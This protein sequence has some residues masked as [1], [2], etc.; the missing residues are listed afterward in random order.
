L[1]LLPEFFRRA[2][3][4]LVDPN[5]HLFLLNL[6]QPERAEA[7]TLLSDVDV[8]ALNLPVPKVHSQKTPE[9]LSARR[10]RSSRESLRLA[11][12]R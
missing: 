7:L 1:P 10:T 11:S 12:S 6:P 3:F 8:I 2:K 4:L 9:H 5:Y